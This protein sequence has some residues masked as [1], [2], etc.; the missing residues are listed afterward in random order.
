VDDW[1]LLAPLHQTE[2]VRFVRPTG[3]ASH[4]PFWCDLNHPETWLIE[5]G[6]Q[7]VAYAMLSLGWPRDGTRH[8]RILDEY[9]GSRVALVDALPALVAAGG[10]DEITIQ[11]MGHDTELVYLLRQR[12]LS[13]HEHT[14]AGTHRIID[15]PGLMK[16]VR[17]YLAERLPAK[18]LRQLSFEQMGERCIIRFGDETL[19]RTL[20]QAAPLVLGGPDAPP[21]AGDL[22]RALSTIFPIPFPMPGFNFL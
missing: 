5:S 3:F 12:G 16:A 13:L 15:L 6:N 10:I 19:E 9:A 1:C 14:L 4:L 7:P 18:E 22:G 8:V 20:S 21:V 11:A 17:P 2:G